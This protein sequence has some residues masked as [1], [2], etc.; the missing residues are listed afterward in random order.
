P[1]RGDRPDRAIQYSGVLSRP[2]HLCRHRYARPVVDR[3]R[4][5]TARTRSRLPQRSSQDLSDQAE[6]DLSAGGCE[7]R[8][9]RGRRFIARSRY[10]AAVTNRNINIYVV[11]AG[12]AKQS[13]AKEAGL[14]RFA[15]NTKVR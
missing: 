2:A 10:P 6:R 12:E 3:D 7:S 5:G 9:C 13:M 14:L 11:I 15:R 1:D 4:G 8:F